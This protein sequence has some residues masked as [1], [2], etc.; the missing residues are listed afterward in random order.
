VSTPATLVLA[1]ASVNLNSVGATGNL[2]NKIIAAS[3][4]TAQQS[5]MQSIG[6]GLGS[7]QDQINLLLGKLK[8]FQK[9]IAALLGIIAGLPTSSVLRVTL[10]TATTT[11][12]TA[13]LPVNSGDQ[14]FVFVEA[15]DDT[16]LLAWDTTVF[17]FAQTQ[18]DSTASTYT[19]FSFIGTPDPD[20]GG[21]M[22]WFQTTLALTGQT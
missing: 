16:A 2:A 19:V 15:V 20:N 17:R 5:L 22:R 8:P 7:H 12:I 3:K 9:D 18:F 14:L 21:D 10:V 13:P 6:Q 4:G 1:S 11:T